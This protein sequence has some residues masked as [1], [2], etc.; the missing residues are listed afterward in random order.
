MYKLATNPDVQERLRSEV[1]EVVGSADIVTPDHI[2][3]MP[4]LK[5]TIK[6]TLRS[7]KL[8]YQYTMHSQFRMLYLIH[9]NVTS[10]AYCFG[11]C[12]W[13]SGSCAGL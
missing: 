3:K 6:E 13:S 10:H 12:W 9:Y 8:I 4:Y 1:Q 2:A 7:V 5:N 11:G